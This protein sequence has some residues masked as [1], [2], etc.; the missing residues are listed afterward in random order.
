MTE[1]PGNPDFPEPREWAAGDPPRPDV[2]HEPTPQAAP[3]GGFPGNATPPPPWRAPQ[4]PTPP[5]KPKSSL[6]SVLFVLFALLFFFVCFIGVGF[7][8][9]FQWIGGQS[10][11]PTG[12]KLSFGDK[13]GLVRIEGTIKTGEDMEFWIRSLRDMGK[14]RSVRGVVLRI[15]SPGGAVGASQELQA[16]VLKI[17]RQYGKPVYVSMGDVAA[18]GGYYI[19][20]GAD[21]IFALK[22]TLTGSIGV[23]LSKP[24]LSKLAE[25]L[26]VETETMK[27]GRFKDAG[28]PM[29][30]LT[31]DERAMFDNLIHDT[32]L[33]FLQ[34][35]LSHR[36]DRLAK[37]IRRIT[38]EQWAGY[39]FAQPLGSTPEAFLTAIADGR[40]YTGRQA[41]ELGL[42][43]QIGTLDDTIRA[44]AD[45]LNISGWP[46]I[47][48]A[49]RQPSLRELLGSKLNFLSLASEAPL[50]YRM[51]MP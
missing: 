32:Y 12:L 31:A 35:V 16:M 34:D 41:L 21:E 6:W 33:Q 40:A 13:I 20:A 46:N 19:A 9:L 14:S 38:P 36:E 18:S 4:R 37:A 30:A 22:G 11:R 48:E 43:D 23:I 17:R 8:L 29:R 7:Y 39:R 45:R 28:D 24:E 26:G 47:Q 50:Q 27:S 42:V 1:Y 44:L 3:G 49:T 51:V 5:P 15:N 25:K 10:F 2:P